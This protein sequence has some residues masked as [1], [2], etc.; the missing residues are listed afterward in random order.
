MVAI[1]AVLNKWSMAHFESNYISYYSSDVIDTRAGL[2]PNGYSCNF[3]WLASKKWIA[4]YAP[5]QLFIVDEKDVHI[6]HSLLLLTITL[7][8]R[9]RK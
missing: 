9:D 5:F 8:K 4:L 1:S 7:N 6:L 2:H 3:S